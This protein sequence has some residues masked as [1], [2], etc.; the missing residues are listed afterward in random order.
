MRQSKVGALLSLRK[1]AQGKGSLPSCSL[2]QYRFHP[3]EAVDIAENLLNQEIVD[4]GGSVYLMAVVLR[5]R[6]RRGCLSFDRAERV[7]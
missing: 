4:K 3:S 2:S 5:I 7:F 1:D 6:L